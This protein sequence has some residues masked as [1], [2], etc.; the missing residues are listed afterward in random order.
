MISIDAWGQIN[1]RL[2]V[3]DIEFDFRP[4]NKTAGTEAYVTALSSIL[5]ITPVKGDAEHIVDQKPLDWIANQ[6][7]YAVNSGQFKFLIPNPQD[8]TQTG[9]VLTAIPQSF[10][11][12]DRFDVNFGKRFGPK[13]KGIYT[14]GAGWTAGIVAVVLGILVGVGSA[15]L[16]FRR[17]S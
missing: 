8:P 5:D 11:E 15:Y 9:A 6:L 10:L 13:G 1:D 4:E 14:A 17:R 12:V 2:R 16:F 3:Y 7:E